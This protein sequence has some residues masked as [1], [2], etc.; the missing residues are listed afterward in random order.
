[1]DRID[2]SLKELAKK[3]INQAKLS[4]IDI[5]SIEFVFRDKISKSK[6]ADIRKVVFPT[7]LY[8]NKKYIISVYRSFNELDEKRKY[9]VL[10]HELLHIGEKDKMIKHDVEDFSVIL[11]KYGIKWQDK[12]EER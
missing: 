1:M 11:E 9:I 6:Y 10:L 2:N 3:I 12:I 4:W 5:E 8:T 7:N